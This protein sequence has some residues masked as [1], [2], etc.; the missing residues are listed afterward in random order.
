[1]ASMKYFLFSIMYN[2][3]IKLPL[4]EKMFVLLKTLCTSD[5]RHIRGTNFCKDGLHFIDNGER[6]LARYFIFSLNDFKIFY[7]V[8]LN[9][10][11]CFVRKQ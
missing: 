10:D 9:I 3:Q 5:N 11:H 6:V 8:H 7:A 4:L 2:K 1:M